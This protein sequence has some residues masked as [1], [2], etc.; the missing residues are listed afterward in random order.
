MRALRGAGTGNLLGGMEAQL[1]NFALDLRPYRVARAPLRRLS[2]P[3]RSDAADVPLGIGLGY[4]ALSG[5]LDNR[6]AAAE[7]VDACQ[8]GTQPF[9]GDAGLQL[10]LRRPRRMAPVLYCARQA[11]GQLENRN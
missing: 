11:S 5:L 2:V 3:G 8:R 10:G 1:D 6:L 9:L 7:S 4:G